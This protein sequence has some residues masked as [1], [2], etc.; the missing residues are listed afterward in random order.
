MSPIDPRL[1]ADMMVG[2][3]AISSPLWVH[4]LGNEFLFWGGIVLLLGRLII[5]IR[6]LV[7]GKKK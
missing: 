1:E 2:T 5:F 4:Q 6:D 3:V 7:K